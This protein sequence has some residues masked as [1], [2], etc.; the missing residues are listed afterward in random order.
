L[1]CARHPRVTKNNRR[2][3]GKGHHPKQLISSPPVGGVGASGS[4]ASFIAHDPAMITDR[5]VTKQ[6][7]DAAPAFHPVGMMPFAC[8]CCP[9]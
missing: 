9:I 5:K 1:W 6:Q 7:A 4:E 2:L 3:P 8:S